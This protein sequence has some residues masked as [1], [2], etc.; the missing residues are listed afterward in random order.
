MLHCAVGV[1]VNDKNQVLIA[2]RP[3]HKS[4][5]GFWEFPGGKIEA[6]E[7]TEQALIRELR[8]EVGITPVHFEKLIQFSFS[9]SDNTVL[10][11]V[12]CIYRFEGTEHGKEGQ[13]IAWAPVKELSQYPLLEANHFIIEALLKKL[14]SVA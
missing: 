4:G 8:E 7:S 12:F 5:G 10:L 6:F 9:Y 11:E 1:I 13:P 14:E 2:K 3:P